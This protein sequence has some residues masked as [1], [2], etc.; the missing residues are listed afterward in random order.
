[1]GN[2]IDLNATGAVAPKQHSIGQ[3]LIE[4]EALAGLQAELLRTIAASGDSSGDG[5]VRI[6]ANT[7][8]RLRSHLMSMR[9]LLSE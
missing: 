9:L 3:M 1:M 8:E 2:I 5:R 7:V 6:V 4:A